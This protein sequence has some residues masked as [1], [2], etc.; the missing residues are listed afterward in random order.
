MKNTK[1]H[2]LAV[3]LKLFLQKTFKEVTLKEIIDK[4]GLSKGAFYHYF[5]SKEQL[6]YEIID[7]FFH[8]IMNFDFNA[9]PSGSLR[10]FYRT[11]AEQAN[12]Q[13]FKFLVNEEGKEEDF[14]TLNFFTLLF[15]AFRL[16][17]AFR[18][19]MED[20]HQKELDAWVRVIGNA[21]DSGEISSPLTNLQIAQIFMFTS[22]GLTMNLTMEKNT[23]ELNK[24]LAS[25][26]DN[27]YATIK[28]N[29]P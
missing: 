10:K 14:I 23:G 8:A 13:R 25:L 22:D 6:F 19:N 11:Y 7:H 17:P 12:S 29:K 2:I 15:D 16:F 4:T 9:L 28:T 27:F 5:N 3:S 26:W 20:Y 18:S 1:N 24:K 21:R